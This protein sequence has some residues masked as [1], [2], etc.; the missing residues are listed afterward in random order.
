[1]LGSSH[2]PHQEGSGRDDF[3]TQATEVLPGDTGWEIGG[4]EPEAGGAAGKNQPPRPQRQESSTGAGDKAEGGE[5]EGDLLRGSVGGH[6]GP[7]PAR[8]QASNSAYPRGI[9]RGGGGHRRG[10][11]L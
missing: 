3:R 6:R 11:G 5:N 10:P 1:M 4:P 2:H 7:K 8:C 9:V